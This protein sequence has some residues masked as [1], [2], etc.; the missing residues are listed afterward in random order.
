LQ[1]GQYGGREGERGESSHAAIIGLG[2][3]GLLASSLK[4]Y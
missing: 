2:V 4:C 3:A 1:V